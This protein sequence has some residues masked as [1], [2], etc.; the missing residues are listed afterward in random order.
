MIQLAKWWGFGVFF[1]SADPALTPLSPWR[2]AP[3]W[4]TGGAE[5]AGLLNST[6]GMSEHAD[7][8]S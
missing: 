6:A 7:T 5:E 3:A 4:R 8:V 1:L 2:Q